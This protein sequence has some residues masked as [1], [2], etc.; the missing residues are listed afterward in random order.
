M[1]VDMKGKDLISIHDLS[2]EEVDQILD[3]THI[4]K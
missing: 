4:L 3:T 2:R 1:A